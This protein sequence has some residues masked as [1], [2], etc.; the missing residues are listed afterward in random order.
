MPENSIFKKQR[1]MLE[2]WPFLANSDG[3]K[4]YAQIS[5]VQKLELK[6]L[7][8]QVIV[9]YYSERP[10]PVLEKHEIAKMLEDEFP[11]YEVRLFGS[12]SE[13]YLDEHAVLG[14][15]EEL[16][17]L[18]LPLNGF[19]DSAQFELAEDEHGTKT[20]TLRVKNGL[21][22]LTHIKFDE[23]L[24]A[25]IFEKT[26]CALQVKLVCNE[27]ISVTDVEK[28]LN[29]K[30]PTKTVRPKNQGPIIK[31]NGANLDETPSS[32]M[33][34][35]AFTPK[36]ADIVSLNEISD[37]QGQCA[38]WG[39]VFFVECRENY[40]KI[41]T[42]SITDYKGSINLKILLEKGENSGKLDDISAGM[43]VVVRGNCT[44][45]KYER[46]YVVYPKDILKVDHKKRTDNAQKKRVE[47]HLHTKLSNMDSIT[48]TKKVIKAAHDMGH[49]AIAITDHG[50]AQAFPEAMGMADA[51]RKDDPTFKV[52][53][54]VEAYFV[55]DMVPV[56]HGSQSAEITAPTVVFDLETTGLSPKNDRITEIG[57]V[58]IENGEIT[59]EFST[60]V[61]PKM[62]IPE[63]V[64]KLTG[65]TDEMV[66]DAPSEQQALKA[67]LEFAD[68]R[69][70]VAHNAHSFDMRFVKQTAQRHKIGVNNTY[71]DTLPLAGALYIGL[72]NYK[73]DT[74][75]KKL[76][77]PAFNHHRA[78]DDARALALAY[79]KMADDLKEKDILNIQEIN[80]GLGST[81]ALSKKNFHTIL[82]VKNQAG[83]KNLFKIISSSHID[84]YLKVPRVP[85][86][87][88]NKHR[89]GLIVGSACEAGELYRAVVEG[90]PHEE[91]LRIADYYD[92]LE[93]QPVGNNEYMVREGIVDGKAKIREFNKTVIALADEL[94]KPCVATGDV[95]FFEPKDSVYRAI[96]QAGMGFSDA[97]NQAPLYFR[98]TDEMMKE[99][100]YLPREKAHEIVVDNPCKIADVIES[101]VR[102]I[103]RGL[104]SPTIDGADE[105]LRSDT[106]AN[107][108]KR[109]GDP[110]PQLVEDRL[111]REL[112]SIIK[113]GFAVL[114]VIAQKLVRKSEEYGYL[115]GSRGSVGSSAV[116]HFAGIS[117]VNSLPAHYVCP[118]CMYSEFFTDGSVANG[119]DLPAK[120][121]PM[122]ER[123]LLMDGHDI[124]FE[125]FLGFD[126]DKEPDID[127]NFSGE[128]QARIHR[129]TEEIFGSDHVFKAGTITGLQDKT[130]YGYVKK[131]LEERNLLVNKAEENRLV[132]GCVGVKKSTGQ[133]PGGMVVVPAS[134]DV[135]DFC[136]IQHPADDKEKGLITTHFEFK[137]LHETILKLDELGH[138]VP[139]MY[140][141]LEDM[142]GIK[143]DS[144]P[145]NDEKVLSL[146]TSTSA[147]NVTPEDIGSETGTFG[148]PELGTH[149]VRN[150]LVEAQPKTFSD[151]IQISGL[152]HGTD[153]WSGNAQVLIKDSV[154][155]ISDVIATRD[156]IM[157]E[158]MYKGVEPKIAF[159][160]MELTRKGLVA[161]FGFPDDF[162]SVL[163]EHGVEDWYIESCKKIKYMFPK[164]HA[165]AYLI[166]AMRIMWFKVYKPLSYYATYFSVHGDDIDYAAAIGGKSAAK[167]TIKEIE[168]RIKEEKKAKDESLLSSLQIVNE[169]L[170]R[171][172]S[173]L[174]I[175][176]GKS[177]A[178]QY[179]IEDGKIRLP[180]MALKGVGDTAAQALEDATINGEK[181]ISAEEI[182]IKC[183]ISDTVVDLLIEINALGDIPRSNQ[184]SF[185]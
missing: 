50:V 173:F 109:Y 55:D 139:T 150:M 36:Q 104:Y 147:L 87:L 11:G 76:G 28:L 51:L 112:D 142:T 167:K 6:N 23:K 124:P 130:A 15:I 91:L 125:T 45:D 159:K 10:L 62:R 182:Q 134:Y 83:M 12:F 16:K 135:Y 54:G 49:R 94:G 42:I 119:F 14:I 177:R 157:T 146:L 143:V 17:S 100:N 59:Q 4:D 38:M 131:Y 155:T 26:G 20:L 172:F 181:Y 137:Y 32:I 65:I 138:F 132:Q 74:V 179:V 82:L 170:A 110:L 61:N 33:F 21:T 136:P 175:E 98:T 148:I 153:V 141:H 19:L 57:A 95:H 81:R 180:F 92:Y 126:G 144:V 160:V 106:M 164:A 39:D 27:K 37:A 40:K 111:N 116:A 73:L 101:D 133:H 169:M 156:S 77:V 48:D 171:G 13:K 67:F 103:P 96:L 118:E 165:V 154:C 151:L 166:A 152:S 184:V 84:Y 93:V 22:I 80:T 68:G 75:T 7:H 176:I 72:K 97:D 129:Y 41:Y 149:F 70:L 63:K 60:F 78:N 145:M 105:T 162:E 185:F 1:T 24:Q 52:I 34:G 56:V 113:H 163:K 29:K 2:L 3:V 174:P 99:F 53:Y 9:H 120:K 121:C 79:I 140:K 117:E 161:K 44:Y 102:P 108:K 25:E 127:L 85:R 178:K 158:L 30:V 47:L 58:L 107:A 90:R 5:F 128:V 71:V 114:Y 123:D 115:V 88:L 86:S 8:K 43:T 18:G 64:I 35:R 122:C 66:K 168:K 69:P 46:D 183:G 31:I 89:H